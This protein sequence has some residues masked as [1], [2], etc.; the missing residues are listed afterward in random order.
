[1]YWQCKFGQKKIVKPNHY[2]TQNNSDS[3]PNK[4]HKIFN[5]I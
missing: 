4:Y 2:K 3:Q 5:N 1:M